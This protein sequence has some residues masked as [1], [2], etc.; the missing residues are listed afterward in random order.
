MAEPKAKQQHLTK[1]VVT[2]L[3]FCAVLLMP[4][5]AIAQSIK[6]QGPDNLVREGYFTVAV[7]IER[8]DA[9][10]K[11]SNLLIE[12]SPNPQFNRDVRQFPALGDFRQLSLSG[13]SDGTYYLRAR[14]NNISRPSNT[15]TINV[16]HYPLWQALGLFFTG[17]IIFTLLVVVLI[18]AHRNSD[19]EVQND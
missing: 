3:V 19:N 16:Q 13:F 12:A 18:S 2:L 4:S 11:L 6:L 17:L 9:V 7:T 15:I 8:E 1:C 10:D 5:V 14:A